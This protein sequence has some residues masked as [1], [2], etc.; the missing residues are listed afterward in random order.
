MS[1]NVIHLPCQKRSRTSFAVLG[2]DVRVGR[3]RE[4]QD[5]VN[6]LRETFGNL[7]T[8]ASASSYAAAPTRRNAGNG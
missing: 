1:S 6:R 4:K 8:T 5:A 3:L 7:V 2:F